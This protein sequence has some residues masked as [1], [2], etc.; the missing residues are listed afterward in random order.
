MI[1]L[2]DNT[3][4][5]RKRRGNE[6]KHADLEFLA[7]IIILP[8]NCQSHFWREIEKEG[9]LYCHCGEFLWEQHED[10]QWELFVDGISHTSCN[11]CHINNWYDS[12][13]KCGYCGTDQNWLLPMGSRIIG[14]DEFD[15]TNKGGMW[16]W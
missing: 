16:R 12:N 11:I 4:Y 6:T 9:D 14:C 1:R 5:H 13:N 8:T 15:L 3:G 2:I 7:G 10:G